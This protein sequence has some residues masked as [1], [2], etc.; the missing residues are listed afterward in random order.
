MNRNLMLS[1]LAAQSQ[2]A[3]VTPTDMYTAKLGALYEGEKRFMRLDA[4]KRKSGA[5][6][7]SAENAIYAAQDAY[8]AGKG[9]GPSPVDWAV[10]HATRTHDNNLYKAYRSARE[11]VLTRRG[12]SPTHPQYRENRQDQLATITDTQSHS[13]RGSNA[14]QTARTLLDRG[15]SHAA[16]TSYLSRIMP[17]ERA[18]HI[19]RSVQARR[20]SEK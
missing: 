20:D 7:D 3:P 13:L 5:A 18:E 1:W 15:V 12:K 10:T 17:R 4:A 16:T 9:P 19:L 6:R 2:N 11:K 14:P 8:N